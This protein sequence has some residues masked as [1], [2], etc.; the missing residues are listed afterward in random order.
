[1]S[2]PGRVEAAALLLALEPPAWHLRHSRAVAEVAGWIALRAARRDGA[3]DRRLVESAAL[4]H[5]L[6]KAPG[7][8]RRADDDHHG[9]A[10]AAW[11]RTRGFAELAAAVAGHPV[12]RLA[13][14]TA[15]RWLAEATLEVRIVAYADKRAGQRLEP[16]ERRFADWRRRYPLGREGAW[17]EAA[18]ATIRERASRLEREVCAAAGLEPHEV[19]RLPWTGAALAAARTGR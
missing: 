3:L 10:G 7:Y 12:V 2:V 17:S 18:L 19:R 5:D 1:M 8:G 11:L 6:D 9:A 15:E 4:L 14:P 16:M 13:D